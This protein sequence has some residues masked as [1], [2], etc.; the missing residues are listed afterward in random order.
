MA[1][2]NFLERVAR[3]DD[4]PGGGVFGFLRSTGEQIANP[5]YKT[6]NEV[7]ALAQLLQPTRAGIGERQRQAAR[8]LHSGGGLGSQGGVLGGREFDRGAV[9]ADPENIKK[10]LGTGLDIGSN[11]IM[12][13]A[14]GAI[15]SFTRSLGRGALAGATAGGAGNI[16]QQL[17][18]TGS[19]S[20]GQTAFGI[21]SGGLFG[22][23]GGVVERI[24]K[25]SNISQV[26][27]AI[28]D[29]LPKETVDQIAPSLAKTKDPN[30]IENIIRRA[31]PRQEPPAA[32]TAATPPVGRA[33]EQAAESPV[34]K[35][36]QG[37]TDLA[38]K[39]RP[40][41]EAAQSA[42]RVRRG[43]AG[44]ETQAAI[45]GERGFAAAKGQLKGELDPNKP[46]IGDTRQFLQ[47]SDV[48]DLFKQAQTHTFSNNPT[49]NFY[50][51]LNTQTALTKILKGEIPTPSET[52]L[53]EEAY[54]PELVKTVSSTSKSNL[55]KIREGF[56]EAINAPRA[57]IS[58]VD[59]SAA[60]RQGLVYTVTKPTKGA[61]ATKEALRQAFS[62]KNFE[63]WLDDLYAQPMYR[64]MADD[65]L[66]IA[67]PRRM[68]GG[69]A[70][71]EERFMT[72][73]ANKVPWVAV[74]ERAY[75]G[76][77]N[78]MR[79]DVYKQMRREL[80]ENGK[81]TEA[82]R[83]G[84]AK[85]INTFTG[86][87]DLGKT[88][89]K[90]AKELNN[91]FFSPRLVAARAQ[92]LGLDPRFYASLPP[93]IRKRAV[94]D[95][96]KTVGAG[97]SVLALAKASG[98]EVQ[99]DPRSS[100]FGKIKIGDTRFD[101]WGGFQQWARVFAQA[102][103]G[104]R[105]TAE[106]IT[107]DANR[108]DTLFSFFQGKLSPTT[109]TAVKLLQG[110][111]QFGEEDITA[112]GEAMSNL[113]PIYIQDIVSTLQEGG[114]ADNVLGIAGAGFVGVGTNTY[115]STAK[116]DVTV[117][118]LDRKYP[119]TKQ[120]SSEFYT[121]LNKS[122]PLRDKY[123]TRINKALAK[124]N[125]NEAQRVAQEFNQKLVE[126][127]QGWADKYRGDKIPPEL[128]EDLNSTI[129][130]LNSRSIQQR[131]RTIQENPNKYELDIDQ[132]TGGQQ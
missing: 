114:G 35:L 127:V 46:T 2:F 83:K 104:K 105:T 122:I 101:I 93:E 119:G 91:V 21:A 58:S 38:R 33:A 14:A 102:A 54:G 15:G 51:Q 5:V 82:N 77:L 95:M 90:I 85:M 29:E 22:A 125:L 63:G 106:D 94:K 112:K 75:S 7:I 92:G 53:L 32:P 55:D 79:T 78:K 124:G 43:A 86:R 18:E 131:V 65:G 73:I 96:A 110:K 41:I 81:D 62:K 61:A 16:G 28:G 52:K 40:E 99:T 56:T 8:T 60:L 129:I 118:M 116:Q 48:D 69:L 74:S 126:N 1:I 42:E 98:A 17:H 36:I 80:I 9:F 25:A 31:S 123:D 23:G 37:W 84:L 88:G 27:K 4:K 72:N 6:G 100:D 111:P 26:K 113:V 128:L 13:G 11:V 57:L 45:G 87:G 3:G 89:N 115:K 103:T 34:N 68:S 108:W 71:K 19:I 44:A 67:D 76:F 47:Q 132:V 117:Q 130:D 107:K 109:G 30:I 49:L 64:D 120:L 10:T 97:M 39:K 66:Y 50:R 70:D 12:P 20:P 121:S 59:M 24:V